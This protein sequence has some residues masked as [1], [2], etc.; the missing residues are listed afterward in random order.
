LENVALFVDVRFELPLVK[1]PGGVVEP[2]QVLASQKKRTG[3]KNRCFLEV[4]R[5]KGVAL[6]GIPTVLTN[7]NQRKG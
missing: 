4:L 2:C 7:N 5:L 6:M 1:S 3:T